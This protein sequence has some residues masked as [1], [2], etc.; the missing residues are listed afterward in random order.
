MARTKDDWYYDLDSRGLTP[1]VV[2]PLRQTIMMKL[3]SRRAQDQARGHWLALSYTEL[4]D[5]ITRLQNIQRSH[6]DKVLP[7]R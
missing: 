6:V 2:L 5:L 1:I 7:R 4:D 3:K